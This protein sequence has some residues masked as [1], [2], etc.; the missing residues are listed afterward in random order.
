MRAGRNEIQGLG[1]KVP[2]GNESRYY[3]PGQKVSVAKC[4]YVVA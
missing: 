3:E 4:P 2:Y 1:L